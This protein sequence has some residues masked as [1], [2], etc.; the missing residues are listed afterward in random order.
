MAGKGGA[1]KGAGRKRKADELAAIERIDAA[2]NPE[3]WKEMLKICAE[4]AKKGS[5]AHLKLLMEYRF[6]KPKETVDVN[7]DNTLTITR[8]VINGT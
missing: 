1:R 6:G 7:S 5:I 3:D 8:K 4:K 2:L